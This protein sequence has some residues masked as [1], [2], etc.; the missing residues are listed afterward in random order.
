MHLTCAYPRATIPRVTAK[1]VRRFD[2]GALEKPVKLD[3]GWVKVDGY[4]A[5]SGLLEYTR[6]DG[7][8]WVEYR[9]PEEAFRADVLESFSLVPLT[10]NH[11]PTGLLDAE[12]TKLFQVG[13]VEMPHQDGDKVRA[14]ILVTDSA[15]V[16]QMAAGKVELSCGY[17]CDL[18]FEAGEVDGQ[19][20]DA[21]QRNVRGN[22]VALVH[23]GRAG[24]EVRVRMDNADA[25]VIPSEPKGTVT[26]QKINL[27]G[28]EYEVP[29]TAAQAFEKY[30]K[31]QGEIVA[32]VRAELEK[33]KA[34]GDSAEAQVTSL[35]AELAEA[36]VKVKA[37]LEARVA[38][39]SKAKELTGAEK[40][41]GL[42]DLDVMKQVAE[43]V[44]ALKMD[45]KSEAYV[46]ACFDLAVERGA[47]N[48]ALTH[49]REISTVKHTDGSD[50]VE[51][52]RAKFLEASRNA[53]K[54]LKEK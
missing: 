7:T 3:N 41:D 21:V 37:A 17:V 43:H 30:Q 53:H 16:N 1:N 48:D 45:G 51:V 42:S 50:P 15:V 11:P 5:R 47:H 54:Q 33:A 19:R 23:A 31:A 49:V 22:H 39:E 40:F 20:Y 6:A 8:K 35:K 27:D 52:A 29:E 4:I 32:E 9:P 34:R 36:P 25:E 26:M 2:R 10:N 28:V 13:T 46:Q 24:P 38:L 12:N 14:K 18:D 44:L